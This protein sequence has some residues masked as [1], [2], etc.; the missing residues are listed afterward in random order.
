MSMPAR[1]RVEAMMQ[2][3]RKHLARQKAKAAVVQAPGDPE[4]AKPATSPGLRIAPS[5]FDQRVGY[6]PDEPLSWD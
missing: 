3:A 2:V 6:Q 5:A 1:T 4:N